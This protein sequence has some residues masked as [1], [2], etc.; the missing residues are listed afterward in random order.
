[1]Y[2]DDSLTEQE[3]AEASREERELRILGLVKEE[4]G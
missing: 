1:M 3:L 2:L 4:E